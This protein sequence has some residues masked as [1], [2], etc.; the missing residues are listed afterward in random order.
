MI[1]TRETQRSH[2]TCMDS[3][4]RIARHTHDDANGKALP[5]DKRAPS[6]KEH[7]MEFTCGMRHNQVK[8]GAS[9]CTGCKAR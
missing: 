5:A 1:A 8:M 2:D 9:V 3:F 4:R 6:D 7:D